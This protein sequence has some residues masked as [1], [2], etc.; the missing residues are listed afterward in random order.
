MMMKAAIYNDYGPP[1]VVHIGEVVKPVP[2]P[3]EVL[4][5]IVA[6]TISAGDWRARSLEMPTGFGLIGR[7]IFGVFRPRN[8]VLGSELSGIVEAI[9]SDVTQ[10]SIGDAVIG[11]P[12]NGCHAQFRT[13]PEDGAIIRKPESLTFEQ[14]AG[15]FFGGI[16]AL[17][18]LLNFGKI[19]S[20]ET[21]LINGASGAVGSACVQLAKHFGAEVTGV[22]SAKN[23]DLVRSLGADFVIDYADEDFTLGNKTYDIVVDCVGNAPWAK[24][25]HVLNETGRLL[26]VAGSLGDMLK[27]SFVSKKHG[28]KLVS[29]VSMGNRDKLLALMEIV[30]SGAF[31]PVIDRVFSL[32]NIVE[33]HAYVDRGHKC[34]SVVINIAL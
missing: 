33:A 16:T 24:S 5:K 10:F 12:E 13:M 34:G 17:D 4:I 20:G 23:H 1:E 29:G 27:A 32:E 30:E 31:R 6:S 21:V 9:G 3:N 26:L 22:S 15:L 2:A 11:Y 28:K 14:A 19:T 8:K 18:F 25:K 7:L